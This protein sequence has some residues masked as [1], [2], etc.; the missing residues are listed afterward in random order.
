MNAVAMNEIAVHVKAMKGDA[1]LR[2]ILIDHFTNSNPGIEK[3]ALHNLC[4]QRS[5]NEFLRNNYRRLADECRQNPN[6][7]NGGANASH[8]LLL[9]LYPHDLGPQLPWPTGLANLDPTIFEAWIADR[10]DYQCQ[11]MYQTM[12]DILPA[13]GIQ[14]LP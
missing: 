8:I 3:G 12:N 14:P 13:L 10:F 5:T 7:M 11:S 1:V 2:T 9:H 4:Q 6:A